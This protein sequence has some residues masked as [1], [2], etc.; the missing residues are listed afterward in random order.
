MAGLV[1]RAFCLRYC[2]GEMPFVSIHASPG[3][4]YDLASRG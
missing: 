4:R 2:N 1:G 3:L